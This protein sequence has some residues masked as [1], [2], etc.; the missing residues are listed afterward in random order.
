MSDGAGNSEL[1]IPSGQSPSEPHAG[2]G[3][4]LGTGAARRPLRISY[5]DGRRLRRSV[6]AGIQHVTQDREELD[7][8]N[9]F[10]VPDGDTGTNLALTLNSIAEAV[11]PLDSRS[12]TVVADVAAEA[13]VMAARGNSG[14]LFSRFLLTFADLVRGQERM[15]SVEMAK[16]L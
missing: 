3:A 14:M 11:R 12:L 13:S 2:H 1:P 15:G 6:L 9:V 16:A 4:D 8:I 5:V 10:P 7:R